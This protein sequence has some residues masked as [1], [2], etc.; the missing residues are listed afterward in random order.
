MSLNIYTVNI[1]EQY[2]SEDIVSPGTNIGGDLCISEDLCLDYGSICFCL[3]DNK[4]Y[5]AIQLGPFHVSSVMVRKQWMVMYRSTSKKSSLKRL[6]YWYGTP[7]NNLTEIM[8][9]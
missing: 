1:G 8:K 3:Y 7:S 4:H 9:L 2:Y 5:P 6:V